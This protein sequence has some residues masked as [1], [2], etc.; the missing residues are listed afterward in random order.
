VRRPQRHT[1]T[2]G[3]A[4]ASRCQ[5]PRSPRQ[6]RH[7]ITLRLP[8]CCA[9][10]RLPRDQTPTGRTGRPYWACPSSSHRPSP[11]AASQS[12]TS[13]I[14]CW[15]WPM[16]RHPAV[17]S[18]RSQSP[19]RPCWSDQRRPRGSRPSRL[20][21][22]RTWPARASRNRHGP[23]TARCSALP[24]RASPPRIQLRIRRDRTQTFA[25][26]ACRNWHQ[27]PCSQ[28]ALDTTPSWA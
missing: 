12:S 8:R 10:S 16:P 2:S 15:G 19:S 27:F 25:R 24:G 9:G 26:T 11:R 17:R 3:L 22:G 7:P 14:P 28:Q 23:K 5:R 20:L 4:L 6:R 1:R 18:F 13:K 21:Q